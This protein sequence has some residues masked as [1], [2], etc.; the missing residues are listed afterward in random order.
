MACHSGRASTAA[1]A[2]RPGHRRHRARPYG[3][4]IPALDAL[5]APNGLLAPATAAAQTLHISVIGGTA[6]VGKTALAVYWAHQVAERL[7]DGWLFVNL[8]GF[9]PWGLPVSGTEAIRGLLEALGLP[10]TRIPLNPDARAALCRSLLAG[11]RMLVLLDNAR[12]AEQVRPLLPGSP[13]HLVVVT[14]RS[15]LTGLVATRRR[16]SAVP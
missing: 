10:P 1:R 2:K 13:G 14:S 12:D 8:R 5:L 4:A 16:N 11:R 9:D 15:Q 6:G 7:P 3:P